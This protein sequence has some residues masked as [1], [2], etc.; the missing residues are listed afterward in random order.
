MVTVAWPTAVSVAA[1]STTGVGGTQQGDTETLNDAEA[2]LAA[3]GE[4]GAAG[5]VALVPHRVLDTREAA[6]LGAGDS[7]D[8]TVLGVGGVPEVGVDAVVLNVTVARPSSDSWLAV[9]PKGSARP[10]ASNLNFSAR[11]VVANTVIA[12]VGTD[13]SVSIYNHTGTT[14]VI[15][16]VQGWFAAD[17]G[18][19]PLVPD[20]LLDTRESSA[21]GDDQVIELTVL[22]EGGVPRSGVDAVVLN[23]TAVRP[24]ETSWLTVFP[25]GEDT[26]LASNLNFVRG[27]NVPNLVIV[28]VGADG[29]IAIHN[30]HGT[31][32]VVVDVQGWFAPA[33]GYT[34]VLPSRLLDTREDD[35]IEAIGAA[36]TIEI[37]VLGRGGVP[38]AG[39]DAVVLNVTATRATVGGWFTVFPAG[40]ETPLASNLNF[41]SGQTVP[42]VVIA[43][44]GVD[45]KV[46]IENAR[47]LT[48]AVVDVQGWFGTGD[49]TFYALDSAWWFTPSH[50]TLPPGGSAIV[51][52]Q[53]VDGEGNPSDSTLPPG[54]TMEMSGPGGQVKMEHLGGDQWRV[55]AGEDIATV[56]VAA[57]VPHWTIGAQLDVTVARV[58]PETQL[59]TDDE[60]VFPRTAVAPGADPA[61]G[62][63]TDGPGAF[64]WEEYIARLH[65]PSGDEET[66]LFTDLAAGITAEFWFPFVLRGAA[67]AVGTPVLGV[68]SHALLGVVTEPPGLPSLE[69]DGMS[70]VSLL[71]VSPADV[72]VDYSADYSY[73]QMVALGLAE[74]FGEATEVTASTADEPAAPGGP[75]RVQHRAPT[76]DPPPTPN[77]DP[78]TTPPADDASIQGAST[79]TKATQS[80]RQWPRACA[81]ELRKKIL[82]QMTASVQAFEIDPALKLEIKP[83]FEVGMNVVNREVTTFRMRAGFNMKVTF[84]LFAKFMAKGGIEL[85]CPELPLAGYEANAPG[86]LAALLSFYADLRVTLKG[87]ISFTGGPRL[88]LGW[89]RSWELEAITGFSW[90]KGSEP[91]DLTSSKNEI[92]PPEQQFPGSTAAG[93]ASGLSSDGVALQMELSLGLPLTTPSGIRV[94]GIITNTIGQVFSRIVDFVGDRFGGTS[95]IDF[96]KLPMVEG[97]LGPVA[98]AVWENATNTLTTRDVATNIGAGI[99]GKIFVKL[100]VKFFLLG[101]L[102]KK[103]S[104]GSES[105]TE[106]VIAQGST[107]LGTMY[108]ALKSIDL[109][110]KIKPKGKSAFEDASKSPAIFIQEDDTLQVTSELS[111]QLSGLVSP[112]AVSELKEG[113]LYR[114][115]DQIWVR[116]ADIVPKVIA[117]TG[118]AAAYGKTTLRVELLIDHARCEALRDAPVTY[119]L[120]GNAPPTVF[121]S[122]VAG[123]AWGDVFKVQCVDGK[124]EL[125]QNDEAVT[126]VTVKPRDTV[127]VDIHTSGAYAD[128][129]TIQPVTPATIPDWLSVS[130]ESQTVERNVDGEDVLPLELLVLVDEENP[131][132]EARTAVIR[133]K[134]KDR[135]SVDLTVKETEK[136]YLRFEPVRVTGPGDVQAVLHTAGFKETQLPSTHARLGL[137]NWIDL[138]A[139]VA[140]RPEEGP[141]NLWVPATD[142][143][144]EIQYSFHVKARTPKCV[145]QLPR[146]F[147][148]ELDDPQ[149]GHAQL[150]IN[151]PAVEAREGCGLHFT[152][153]TINIG[154]LTE[155]KLI[156]DQLEGGEATAAWEIVDIPTWMGVAPKEGTFVQGG[157]EIIEVAGQPPY[158]ECVGRPQIDYPL[159]AKATL[160]DRTT[161][162]ARLLISYPAIPAQ[163]CGVVR[164]G[165]W[166]GDPHLTTFDGQTADTQVLGEYVI[167][168]PTTPDPSIPTVIGRAEL[169][170]PT[171]VGAGRPTSVT[172]V[173]VTVEGHTFEVYARPAAVWL[174][175]QPFS[176]DFVELG[177]NA[178]LRRGT[179]GFQLQAGQ[180]IIEVTGGFGT[181]DLAVSAPYGAPVRGLFGTPNGNRDDDLGD[182]DGVTITETQAREHGEDLYSFTDSWRLTS[183][184]Q[185]SLSQDYDGFDDPNPPHS[186]A[187]LSPFIAEIEARMGDVA[188]VCSGTDSY[189]VGQLALELYIGRDIDDVIVASCEYVVQGTVTSAT[190][191]V[192]GVEVTLDGDGVQPCVTLTLRDGTYLCRLEPDLTEAAARNSSDPLV[193]TVDARFPGEPGV[194]TGGSVTFAPTAPLGD[195]AWRYLALVVDPSLLSKVHV[196]GTVTRNGAPLDETTVV[197][198]VANDAEG[199]LFRFNRTLDPAADGSYALDFL[200][201]YGTTEITLTA[202]YGV[203]NRE[204]PTIT[205]PIAGEFVNLPWD[206]ASDY[207][208]VHVHGVIT[209]NGQPYTDP[210]F[211]TSD[212]YGPADVYQTRIERLVQPDSNG[213]YSFDLLTFAA[214]ERVDIRFGTGPTIEYA[215]QFTGFAVAPGSVDLPLD[216]DYVERT[217]RASGTVLRNGVVPA[218]VQLKFEVTRGTDAPVTTTVNVTPQAGDGAYS[219]DLLVPSSATSAT[220]TLT[221]PGAS[222]API[223]STV[224]LTGYL[225]EVSLSLSDQPTRLTVSGTVSR[226]GVELDGVPP[227]PAPGGFVQMYLL[228]MTGYDADGNEVEVRPATLSFRSGGTYETTTEWGPTVASVGMN[229]L[230]GDHG[231]YVQIVG[232]W[233]VTGGQNNSVTYSPNYATLDL[234]LDIQVAGQPAPANVSDTFTAIVRGADGGELFRVPRGYNTDSGGG[235][236]L[237]FFIPVGAGSIDFVFDSDPGRTYTLDSLDTSDDLQ[238]A[239]GV[240]YPAKRLRLAMGVS[241]VAGAY[242]GGLDVRVQSFAPDAA[243]GGHLVEVSNDE[244][245]ESVD[246]GVLYLD[247]VLPLSA[248]AATVEYTLDG[249]FVSR[250]FELASDLTDT[251]F[252]WFTGNTVVEYTGTIG[253]GC[254]GVPQPLT[255]ALELVTDGSPGADVPVRIVAPAQY[256]VP[257]PTTGAYRVL[258]DMPDASDLEGPGATFRLVAVSADGTV[259]D[260]TGRAG[261]ALVGSPLRQAVTANVAPTCTSVT[262]SFT[263]NGTLLLDGVPWNAGDMEVVITPYALN[264]SNAQVSPPWAALGAITASVT[265]DEINGT[266]SWTGDVPSN[267]T[268]V[269]VEQRPFGNSNAYQRAFVLPVGA[270]PVVEAFDYDHGVTQVRFDDRFLTGGECTAPTLMVEYQLYAFAVEPVDKTGDPSTWAGA[271]PIELATAVPALTDNIA[272]TS[273][274]LPAD[275]TYVW[276][277]VA[278]ASVYTPGTWTS[279]TSYG[280]TITPDSY[281]GFG[282]NFFFPCT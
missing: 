133:V 152:P 213:A 132:C 109:S 34:S 172:A 161:K 207:A 228:S 238:L 30:A 130:P 20:R 270:G 87:T 280:M 33:R 192:A 95:W 147:V 80:W 66:P 144:H 281:L 69:R 264:P 28:K 35:D 178:S 81:T 253:A 170:V 126:A 27:Q 193:V 37:D 220:V 19:T 94:G 32:H 44:V 139:P 242:S 111:P 150:T 168:Q 215:M 206:I 140:D 90:V 55:V 136:C 3:V 158:D 62:V 204:H 221:V 181:L 249:E 22:G 119:A 58:R 73:D 12:K 68:E 124:V 154:E 219:Y 153:K 214:T 239:L 127:T 222:A 1:P 25:A 128:E 77:A 72:F 198:V 121:G 91:S 129:I 100:P 98:K 255:L 74:E 60:I 190:L 229:M 196:A 52:L 263:V 89:Q 164:V 24:T 26:P 275:T 151:D 40:V 145:R 112:F 86:E 233:P 212:L 17:E 225:A 175:G 174:D 21:V 216:V 159:F 7:L 131:V 51:R 4:A 57:Q 14:D 120:I 194:V 134:T 250:S 268:V 110:A 276:V 156:D 105:S 227:M 117:S 165:R 278:P 39:V 56:T 173:A 257:D 137:P 107:S 71:L 277:S 231:E 180:I 259:A 46:L 271:Q 267:A 78:P 232:R 182:R 282:N 6:P 254:S 189:L 102:A 266:W 248:T 43:K 162:D 176:S 10:L 210:L 205:A 167:I 258:F 142:D 108:G 183:R 42:N 53:Q 243:D 197:T 8:L 11:Q 83:V 262:R 226:L 195:Q 76:D 114:L 29:K 237:P 118:A 171:A 59:F 88:T 230:L 163:D 93:F 235:Q 99:E 75:S 13:G 101:K 247:R 279:A 125:K 82:E 188:N 50:V 146:S 18:Y 265:I 240:D 272:H 113:W 48:D 141:F 186:V 202:V 199:E 79:T 103:V 96:A 15:V 138:I 49:P 122:Q 70:L 187:E 203:D 191:P 54:V 274:H 85:A 160:P 45:G 38:D 92:T 5:Y 185:S 47:G 61:A 217:I 241:G 184:S 149:R 148:L 200:A 223:S 169:T 2:T 116:E 244:F 123:Y 208:I 261:S 135:G 245:S 269:N 36:D 273:F 201:P 246:I 104:G 23:V 260:D 41:R 211:A 256:V 63:E 157:H 218:S 252:N 209:R 143:D 234:F 106:F 177:A 67:P 97:E 64:T 179:D 166:W 251:D 155:L 9:Y 31:S 224:A 115:D 84:G 65:M 16:D 236:V